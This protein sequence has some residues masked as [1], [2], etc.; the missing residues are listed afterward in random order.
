MPKLQS[1]PL[2]IN[3]AMRQEKDGLG[4]VGLPENALY[5]ISTQ[6]AI[7]NFDVS[8]YRSPEEFI[9]TLAWVKYACAKA[10]QDLNQISLSKAEAIQKAAFEITEGQW[11]SEFPIDIFQTGSGTSLNMNMNEVLAN[12]AAQILGQPIGKKH[13]VHPND[14]CNLGQSSNDVIPTTSNMAIVR[15]IKR[16]LI[17]VLESCYH[18]LCKRSEEWKNVQKLGRTHL[19]DAVPL[20]LGEEFSAYAHQIQKGIAKIKQALEP[21][22][23]LPIGG[24]AV[25]TG[26]NAH[27]KFGAC[28]VAILNEKLNEKFDVS[29]D[30]FEGQAT[31]DDYVFLVGALDTVC[32][33]LFKIASD[34]RWM[35]SGPRSGLNELLL[36]ALQPGS[37]C[38]PGKINPVLCEM[39]LQVLFFVQGNGDN[40]RRCAMLGSQFQ[41]NT[42]STS[43]FYSLFE[44]IRILSNGVQK[45]TDV[46]LKQLKP[47]VER[48]QK[49]IQES[50]CL[51]TVC[52]PFIGYDKAT[53]FA[54]KAARLGCSLKEVLQEENKLTPS[55][56]LKKALDALYSR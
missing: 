4:E 56:Q 49:N 28:V 44:S 53:A 37:S 20:T 54:Q 36:P 3:F 21:L 7:G 40:I 1:D 13:P 30:R 52:A 55:P 14:D 8:G 22:Y 48:L 26:V 35:S 19:M 47:N 17:P 41:L 16:M 43:L 15:S 10:N 38:M 23:K 51:A 6:R 34:I 50:L 5:G 46:Y 42:A 24:T 33:S 29:P 27:P 32:T 31:R 18:V 12:R 11:I 2:K 9:R 45:F 39:L 25:G